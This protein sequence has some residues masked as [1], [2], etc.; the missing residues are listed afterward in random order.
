MVITIGALVSYNSLAT[1][2]ETFEEKCGET[3]GIIFQN[4]SY[5]YS[6]CD[7]TNGETVMFKDIK[8]TEW[9]GC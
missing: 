4:S 8:K 6:V 5:D 9:S 1:N 2:F 7:C 3:G